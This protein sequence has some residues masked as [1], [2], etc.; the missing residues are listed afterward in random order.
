M[1]QGSTK[2][3]VKGR[4][5]KLCGKGWARLAL[6]GRGWRSL[7][8]AV[9]PQWLL[10]LMMIDK[11][12]ARGHVVVK[13][14][15]GQLHRSWDCPWARAAVRGGSESKEKVAEMKAGEVMR[16]QQKCC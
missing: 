6:G 2:C 8:E 7:G 13:A 10:L 15:V 12:R 16:M 1:Q 4:A 5:T 3:S 11:D 9:V 14:N